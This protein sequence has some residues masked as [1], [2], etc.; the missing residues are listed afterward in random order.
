[1][2][3]AGRQISHGVQME[4]WVYFHR[5]CAVQSSKDVSYKVKNPR[6]IPCVLAN[7][8]SKNWR[9]SK[10]VNK[11]HKIAQFFVSIS[12]RAKKNV[13]TDQGLFL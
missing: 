10:S 8:M 3:C 6:E 4:F 5:R 1:M 13:C 9:R 11:L 12:F 7:F 2:R